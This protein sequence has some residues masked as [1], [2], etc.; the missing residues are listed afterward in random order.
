ML[1]RKKDRKIGLTAQLILVIGVLSLII[2][3]GIGIMA[4]LNA[5]RI[6]HNSI[7]NSLKLLSVQGGITVGKELD[8]L[9]AVVDT[10]AG[11]DELT[12]DNTAET[13]M[14]ILK[15]ERERNGFIRMTFVGMD[16]KGL[17]TDGK[18][19]DL[20]A[21]EYFK[22]AAGGKTNVSDPVVS[23][24][25]NSVVVVVAAP[26][27]SGE[28][29]K[30]VLTATVEGKTL[31]NITNSI[32]FAKDGYSFML[33]KSGTKIAHE[34]Y[35]LVVKMDN[36][37]DNVKKAPSL[38]ALVNLEKKMVSGETGTGEYTYK[39]IKKF[40]GY[41][42]VP[43]TD[44]SIG[45]TAPEVSVFSDLNKLRTAMLVIGI[46]FF[47][48]SMMIAYLISFWIG[49]PIVAMTELVGNMA[50]F[51]LTAVESERIKKTSGQSN[52][53]GMIARSVL[54]LK[55]EFHGVIK[56]VR[57]EAQ[58]V[59]DTVDVAL[60][61]IEAL[62]AGIQD[63][64]ATTEQLSAGMEE[65]AAATQE[66]NAT[67]AEIESAVESIAA[68]SQEGAFIASEIGKRAG[69]LSSS[70][71]ESQKNARAIL[72]KTSEKLHQAIQESKSVEDINT[73]S[74]TIMQITAQTNLLA[75]NAAIE[76]ARAGESGKGFAVVAEEIRKL[77]EDS[78]TAVTQIQQVIKTVVSSVENL[79][80]NS[81]ELLGFVSKDVE[82]DYELM[83]R[84]TEQYNE[85][86]TSVNNM[87][88]D[89]SATSEELLAS[90]Q[91]MLKAIAEVSSAANEGAEGT[92]NIAER[93]SNIV[94]K[95]SEV[96]SQVVKS[97]KSADKL[98]NLVSK[99][100]V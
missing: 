27:K 68:R 36:D 44:W 65:T 35:D 84:A 47:I 40:M 78:R 85:D 72:D 4:D 49:R 57:M 1:N 82:K 9:K 81:N 26:I 77:A 87:T 14:Q 61:D 45:T 7:D 11:M 96:V 6:L 67:S 73:L 20:S 24:N 62:N 52:E 46:I 71:G 99:F 18:T 91:N 25:D 55:K 80:F 66:M 34:N 97:K 51:D 22:L 94:N 48:I 3:A 75:L 56:G 70:F 60:N 8:K 89:F 86:A 69:E 74:D 59:T 38:Q 50:A 53:I 32:V 31:S 93:S 90:I 17:T 29:I 19:P 76:A 63:V 79:A 58:E 23:V 12:G 43:G 88:M 39:G 10:V 42:P 41:A 2:C 37:F 54:N 30:G 21:R 28:E 100:R 33:S 16:G 64:S 15:E 92:S 83:L 13:R 5:T 95:S 98:I